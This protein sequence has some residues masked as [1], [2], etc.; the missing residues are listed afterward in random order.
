MGFFL[1]YTAKRFHEMWEK[2][3]KRQRKFEAIDL[4]NLCQP[5]VDGVK[6]AK[7]VLLL[8]TNKQIL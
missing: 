8:L 2:P 1:K 6:L 3:K 5:L 7:K 4:E